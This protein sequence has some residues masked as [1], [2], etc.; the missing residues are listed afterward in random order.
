MSDNSQSKLKIPGKAP[1][2]AIRKSVGKTLTKSTRSALVKSSG[3][4]H[5]AA[6]KLSA[7]RGAGSKSK[8]GPRDAR[9]TSALP[10]AQPRRLL[11]TAAG[12]AVRKDKASAR[13]KA[14]AQAGFDANSPTIQSSPTKNDLG[15][16]AGAGMR[17]DESAGAGMRIDESAGA[18]M[19]TDE[20]AGASTGQPKG[21]TQLEMPFLNDSTS[22]ELAPSQLEL[23][24]RATTALRS[25]VV[26]VSEA[27]SE[28]VVREQ[29]R[30]AD[31]NH[32]R[33]EQMNLVNQV[34]SAQV[35]LSVPSPVPSP[36]ALPDIPSFA[37]E[38]LPNAPDPRALNLDKAAREIEA[39]AEWV[40]LYPQGISV[41]STV[42]RPV[43]V[44]KDQRGV[45]VLPVWMNPLDA[46][47][48]IAE[49]T[50]SSGAT[51]HMVSRR[52]MEALK[53][54]AVRCSFVELLGH[55][56]YVIVEFEGSME[57]K[58]IRVRAD[59]A[60]SFCVQARVKFQATRAFMRMCRDVDADMERLE[61]GNS[62]T[63]ASSANYQSENS[64]KKHPY[65]I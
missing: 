17:I 62:S 28:A 50:T 38:P 22:A 43:L 8:T 9:K 32:P 10:K 55:H 44:M 59:E 33:L 29:S 65:V 12:T 3:R 4:S 56:Q 54:R 31:V 47:I 36:V 19:R 16:S 53:I 39:A 2:K 34:M 30:L 42:G 35:A 1:G 46:G 52:M 11:T 14:S 49:L 13:R 5:E 58:A 15:K 26:A 25:A 7:D 21:E 63:N 41:T 20:S 60:M 18:S 6:S 57:L 40:E 23:L 48:A 64:S 61:N 51:P 27:V 24:L 45:E 37:L